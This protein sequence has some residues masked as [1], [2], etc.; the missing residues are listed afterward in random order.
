M[1]KISASSA[2][3]EA[4]VVEFEENS[5]RKIKVDVIFEKL[6]SFGRF[7]QI[8]FLLICIPMMFVSMHV[9]SWTFIVTAARKT[10]LENITT[11][12]V[13]EAYSASDRWDM[14]GPN[15]W[16]RATVQSLYFIGQMIGSFSCGILADRIGRKKVLFICL[17]TQVTCATVLIFAP[18]WWI[19]TIFKAGTGF[20]QPGIYGV[21]VV[22]GIE[23]VGPKYRSMVS[24]TSNIFTCLGS[25]LLAV[26]AYFILDYRFL[27]AAIAIPSLVFISYWWMLAESARWL[28]SKEKFDEANQVLCRAADWNH[29]KIPSNWI[30]LIEKPSGASSGLQKSGKSSNNFGVYDLLRTPQMRKRTLANFLMWPV[31]TMMYYGLSMKSD[32]GGGSLFITFIT[33]SLVEIPASLIVFVL[34]DRIGRRRLFSASIFLA[35]LLLMSNWLAQEYIPHFLAVSFI[36]T[37]KAC[38]TTAYTV[39]Y[40]YTSELF[41]TVIRNTAIGCCSTIARFGAI[42]ASFIAF[43]LVERYGSWCMIVPFTFLAFAAAFTASA[44][45]PETRGKSLPDSISEI[46]GHSI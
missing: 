43:F 6:G 23:L 16:I 46:E 4:I 12:C 34:I 27:H 39:M 11:F 35:G 37:A 30:D 9:M 32:V 42:L 40:T 13:E 21:A 45:L 26:L 25:V 41:P 10:C 36:L 1:S 19:Y 5:S 28:V 33:S 2:K 44:C 17:V 3:N 24:V 7:Q 8:Q 14:S 20:S 18:T 31:V 38:V 22:L 29:K 15:S